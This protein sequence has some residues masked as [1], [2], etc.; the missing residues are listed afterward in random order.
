MHV[1]CLSC[2]FKSGTRS[3]DDSRSPVLENC[4]L[5]QLKYVSLKFAILMVSLV[6]NEWNGST[7][8]WYLQH[9]EVCTHLHL[10]FRFLYEWVERHS[11]ENEALGIKRDNFRRA[12][13]CPQEEKSSGPGLQGLLFRW[14]RETAGSRKVGQRRHSRM[15]CSHFQAAQRGF[16][17]VMARGWQVAG[18][19]ERV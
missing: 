11:G 10:N 7:S 15:R 2:L 5:N 3:M 4:W 12:N 6:K 16:G 1:T 14:Y 18:V 9:L 19:T 13:G 8:K 17:H